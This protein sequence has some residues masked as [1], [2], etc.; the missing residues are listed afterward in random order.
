MPLATFAEGAHTCT[1]P[2]V[3]YGHGSAGLLV[4]FIQ[5]WV[6]IP[7]GTTKSRAIL[8]Q[9]TSCGVQRKEVRWWVGLLVILERMKGPVTR[10]R[11]HHVP[12][13]N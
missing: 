12:G 8:V 7:F 6:F 13:G 4:L 3:G 2:L 11:P 1:P 9:K 10:T 5:T